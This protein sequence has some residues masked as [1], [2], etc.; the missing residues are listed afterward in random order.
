[1][2]IHPSIKKLAKP[3]D[4]LL[5]LEGNP[6]RGDIGAIAASYREFGQVKPIVVRDNEDGTFTV[7]AGNHQLEA[8]KQLGWKEIAAVVLDGD[9]EK[10]IAFALADNRTMELGY[11]EQADMLNMLSQISDS[12]PD[13][14]NDLRWD[15][16]EMAVIEEWTERNLETE[17]ESGY[18]AP[19]MVNPPLGENVRVESNEDGEMVIKT[20][21]TVDAKE[22]ATR[23]STAINSAGS[24][25]IVQYTLVF[26]SPDQQKTWYDFIKFLRSSPVYEGTTTAER[27]IQFIEAHA[28]Y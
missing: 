26:D 1:M 5:P 22:V 23:G 9:D 14:L 15:E 25:A 13:L 10:A 18:V 20:N 16:F 11:S 6:R 3:I 8:A 19:V 28:D 21:P 7:I 12:Y 27:L 2:E 17:E 4:S 24:Q